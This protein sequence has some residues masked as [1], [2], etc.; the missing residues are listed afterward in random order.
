MFP[1]CV[2]CRAFAAGSWSQTC[3]PLDWNATVASSH[4]LVAVCP[5]GTTK[6]FMSGLNYSMCGAGAQVQNVAG[7][8]VCASL[9]PGMPGEPAAAPASLQGA[10]LVVVPIGCMH[11]QCTPIRASGCTAGGYVGSQ[12][13][14]LL[15]PSGYTAGTARGCSQVMPTLHPASVRV[16]LPGCTANGFFESPGHTHEH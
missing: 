7:K 8:L 12:V 3:S 1:K 15:H 10:L 11:Q 13:S 4:T 16:H 2:Y 5:L 14:R 9:A 6:Y